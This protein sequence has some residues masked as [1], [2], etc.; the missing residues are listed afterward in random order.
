MIPFFSGMK[1]NKNPLLGK[2]DSCHPCPPVAI[3]DSKTFL[4][5]LFIKISE[6]IRE[7]MVLL[8]SFVQLTY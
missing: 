6:L 1:R 4:D 5:V 3:R 8:I 2:G 7:V